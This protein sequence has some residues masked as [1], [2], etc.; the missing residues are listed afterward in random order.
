M[1]VVA[2]RHGAVLLC[3]S[4]AGSAMG[5]EGLEPVDSQSGPKRKLQEEEEKVENVEKADNVTSKAP[6]TLSEEHL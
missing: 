5:I 4:R 1:A 6:T 2:P 3:D